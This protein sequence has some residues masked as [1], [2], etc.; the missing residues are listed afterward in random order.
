[1]TVSTSVDG[2][3]SGR[4]TVPSPATNPRRGAVVDV[5]KYRR[6]VTDIQSRPRQISLSLDPG[7][8]PPVRPGSLEPGT[9]VAGMM[10]RAHLLQMLTY[11]KWKQAI[12]NPVDNRRSPG[13]SPSIARHLPS[14]RHC[15]PR[16]QY[17]ARSQV[18]WNFTERSDS[19]AHLNICLSR[20]ISCLHDKIGRRI[21][22]YTSIIKEIQ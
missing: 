13:S 12:A 2:L 20:H 15:T 9:A 5:V 16:K 19:A 21:A 8:R 3:V 22:G 14:Q 17:C 11:S 1:L 10:R 7:L 18:A 4:Q 6:G